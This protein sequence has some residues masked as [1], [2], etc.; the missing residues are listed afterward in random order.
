MRTTHFTADQ[1]KQLRTDLAV[2]QATLARLL[3]VSRRTIVRAEQRGLEA[4]WH[5]HVYARWCTLQALCYPSD[6]YTA[7]TRAAIGFRLAIT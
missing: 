3:T 5:S 1:V 7:I 6:T 2:S 4:P